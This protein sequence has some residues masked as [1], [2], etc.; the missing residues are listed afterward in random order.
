MDIDEKELW[1]SLEN[2][3]FDVP[4]IKLIMNCIE[5]AKK[6]D[7]DKLRERTAQLIAHRA[8]CGSEHDPTHGKLHG[9]CIVC[10]VVWPCEYAGKPSRPANVYALVEEN[11]RLREALKE[12]LI[13]VKFGPETT[14]NG[15]VGYEARIPIEFVL[16]AKQA[17][18]GKTEGGVKP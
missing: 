3:N 17:L 7:A 15:V 13:A 4:E 12:L 14:M 2:C 11:K 16:K 9:Y 5:S 8:C 10:G 6:S 1:E 18:G